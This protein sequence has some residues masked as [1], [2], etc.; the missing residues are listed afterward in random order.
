MTLTVAGLLTAGLLAAAP[1][2][3]SAATVTTPTV[4]AVLPD[5]GPPA[6]GT[7]VTVTGSGFTRVAKVLFGA[8]AGGKV[9]VV[10]S[11]KLTV[12]APGHAAGTVDVRV[13]TGARPAGESAAR[14]ADHYTYVVPPGPVTAAGIT[15]VTTT[16]VTVQWTNPVGRGF[17]GV[18]IRRAKGAT[19][20]SFTSGTLVATT[21][22]TVASLTDK[23]LAPGTRYTFAL[24]AKGAADSRAAPDTVTTT[25]TRRWPSPRPHCRRARPG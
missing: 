8:T 16:T 12:V 1:G 11:G 4:K 15:A 14:P 5:A 9:H 13:V 18:V 25:T 3:A 7:T 21:G 2:T 22:K 10:S 23:G 19:A 17:S 24:F 6:G 20:P